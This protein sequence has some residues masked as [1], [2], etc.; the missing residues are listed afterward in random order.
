MSPSVRV[1]TGLEGK[2]MSGGTERVLLERPLVLYRL[3]IVNRVVEGLKNPSGVKRS[4]AMTSPLSKYRGKRETDSRKEL[5][6]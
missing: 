2:T 3:I 6:T 1:G 5:Y 4:R